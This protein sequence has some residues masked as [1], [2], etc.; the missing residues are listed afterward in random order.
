VNSLEYICGSGGIPPLTLNRGDSWRWAV[1]F[2]S[3][4]LYPRYNWTGG[5][6][7]PRTALE[8][9]ERSQNPLDFKCFQTDT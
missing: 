9:L 1:S 3:Q 2:T 8:P 4:P 7:S 5:W 6:T